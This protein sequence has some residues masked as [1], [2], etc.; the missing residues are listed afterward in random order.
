MPAVVNRSG[1]TGKFAIAADDGSRE[2]SG[3]DSGEVEVGG[4]GLA[5]E[6]GEAKDLVD[7]GTATV[8]KMV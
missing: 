4:E 3:S 6:T 5:G 1:S 7:S 2:V 8:D